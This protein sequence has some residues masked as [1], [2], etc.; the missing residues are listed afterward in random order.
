MMPNLAPA[1]ISL[2]TPAAPARASGRSSGKLLRTAHALRWYTDEAFRRRI[3]RQ[4]NRGE[5]LNDLRRFISYAERGK[6]RYRQ[7]EGQ[8]LQA[9]CNTL[10][11]NTC[12]LSTTGYLQ[13]AITGRDSASDAAIALLSP[14]HFEAINP[15]GD[16][17][18]D[19]AA[20]LA[21][22]SRRPLRRR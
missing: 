18:F 8:T 14:A 6:V 10:V 19:V 13:D 2:A 9:H 5:T 12:I 15:Y 17:R 21:R 3:G 4:L 22:T 11:V 7:L 1:R 16:M 20:I